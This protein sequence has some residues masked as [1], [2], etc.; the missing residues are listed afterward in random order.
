[1][2]IANR[3]NCARCDIAALPEYMYK[4][5][6]RCAKLESLALAYKA[7]ESDQVESCCVVERNT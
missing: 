3:F 1:M 6:G 7:I 5:H 2:K 4:F